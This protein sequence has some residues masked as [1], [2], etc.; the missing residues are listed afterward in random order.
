MLVAEV[1]TLFRQYIDEPD[2]SFFTDA[3]VATSLAAAYEEFRWTVMQ[4]DNSIFQYQ[5]D[6]TLSTQTTYDL[7]NAAS[8]V[9]T[10]GR[11]SNLNHPRMMKLDALYRTSSNV[12]LTPLE[13]VSGTQA[14]AQISGGYLLEGTTI[15]FSEARSGTL[16]MKYFPQPVAAGGAGAPAAATGYVDWTVGGGGT[17][18][19]NLSMFH[20]VI[21]LL[22]AKQYFILDGAVNEVLVSQLGQRRD[23]LTKYL[24][25]RGQDGSQYVSQVYTGYEFGT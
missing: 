10:F 18:I 15:R 7:G 24:N 8:A 19:D 5:V 14:L 25:A 6:L 17:F 16:T 22:A 11:D 2:Q 12:V 20:D 3:M 9:R 1:Q 13:P 23:D 21:A 4:V